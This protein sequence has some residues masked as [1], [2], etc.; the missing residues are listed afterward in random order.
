[1]SAFHSAEAAVPQSDFQRIYFFGFG[2]IFSGLIE[3]CDGVCFIRYSLPQI[4]FVIEG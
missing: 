4:V 1:M 3:H 2:M